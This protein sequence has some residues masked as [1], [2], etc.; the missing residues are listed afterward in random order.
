[1]RKVVV[2][3][4]MSLDGVAEEPNSFI[5]DWDSAMDANLAAVTERQDAVIL[6][7]RSYDEWA[8][9]WPESDIQPFSTFINS[10]KKYVATSTAI[11]LDWANTTAIDEE[12][13]DFVRDLKS[14]PGDEIGVHASISVAQSLLRANLVDELHLV[15]APRIAGAGR[16]LLDGLPPIDLTLIQSSISSTGYLL[17]TY[18]VTR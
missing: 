10:V 4:L 6:G 1:M 15:I 3:E 17:L 8:R 18:G 12:L 16:K 7:R 14:Q 11:D 2:Y 9:F 5:T 13:V